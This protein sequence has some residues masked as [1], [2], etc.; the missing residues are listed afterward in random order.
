[1]SRLY[2]GSDTIFKVPDEEENVNIEELMNKE[3]KKIYK[4]LK[5]DIIKNKKQLKKYI[6]KWLETE[7]TKY[8]VDIEYFATEIF[9]DEQDIT[10]IEIALGVE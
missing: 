2:V 9:D 4:K 10:L 3:T 8:L 7:D 6:N 5:K 1:M